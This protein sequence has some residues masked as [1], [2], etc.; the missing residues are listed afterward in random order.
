MIGFAFAQTINSAVPVAGT[1]APA[2]GLAGFVPLL[3]IFAVFW[4]LVIRPQ[5][6]RM[7]EQKIMI[8]NLKRGDEIVTVGGIIGK[9]DNVIDNNEITVKIADGV[10][11][12][13]AR[14]GV[15]TLLSKPDPVNENTPAETKEKQKDK[16]KNTAKSAKEI[17]KIG[18]EKDNQDNKNNSSANKN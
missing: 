1:T 15:S 9:V 3:I 10:V 6:K 12:K 17:K 4:F 8:D 13:M 5:T 14:Q 16:K 2:G 11:V 7:K 18:T